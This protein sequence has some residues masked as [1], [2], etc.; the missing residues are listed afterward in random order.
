MVGQLE[1]QR[2]CDSVRL[3]FYWLQMVDDAFTTVRD[4]RPWSRNRHTSKKHRKLGLVPPVRRVG[5]VVIAIHDSFRR[6]NR[7]INIS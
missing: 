4:R 5:F 6:Q 7:A 3:E 1:E 2:T